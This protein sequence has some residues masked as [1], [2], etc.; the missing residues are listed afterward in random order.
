MLHETGCRTAQGRVF[1]SRVPD[2]GRVVLGRPSAARPMGPIHGPG[3]V[4]DLDRAL[5]QRRGNRRLRPGWRARRGALV[6]LAPLL[7]Q[8]VREPPPFASTF[9]GGL[10]LGL[11]RIKGPTDFA[12]HLLRRRP[13]RVD[14]P[15]V[16]IDPLE[17]ALRRRL[18]PRAD[19]GHQ[20]QQKHGR[21]SSDAHGISPH[22]GNDRT[23]AAERTPNLA[24]P[25]GFEPATC[26]LGGGHSIQL[27][28]GDLIA[29]YNAL[30]VARGPRCCHGVSGVM[31]P[32]APAGRK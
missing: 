23:L 9:P 8:C 7:G 11:R 21:E 6:A 18:R 13:V 15:A 16:L 19:G 25:A 24:S 5:R 26:P 3:V 31:Q 29:D 20:P 2:M 4:P 30:G 28:Y 17:D 22:T 10:C 27:S 14:H 12:V 1:G 32:A